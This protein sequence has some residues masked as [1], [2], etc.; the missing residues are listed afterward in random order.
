MMDEIAL[1]EDVRA[2]CEDVSSGTR[3]T[4]SCFW[5]TTSAWRWTLGGSGARGV[6][7][8]IKDVVH[9]TAAAPRGSARPPHHP[10]RRACDL[11]HQ[12][13]RASTK[14]ESPAS[15]VA[16]Q[17]PWRGPPSGSRRRRRRAT[18]ATALRSSTGNPRGSVA[19]REGMTTTIWSGHLKQIYFRARRRTCSRRSFDDDVI[20]VTA[21]GPARR[22]PQGSRPKTKNISTSAF[23]ALRD[24]NASSPRASTVE[25]VNTRRV[26]V[27]VRAHRGAVGPALELLPRALS[28]SILKSSHPFRSRFPRALGSLRCPAGRR[29]GVFSHPCLHALFTFFAA[30]CAASSARV[31]RIASSSSPFGLIGIPIVWPAAALGTEHVVHRGLRLA[32]RAVAHHEPARARR[33]EAVRAPRFPFIGGSPA[34]TRDTICLDR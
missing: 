5:R 33:R 12:R 22:E 13:L 32:Q 6:S 25:D 14:A 7:S 28:R 11:R 30:F 3:P 24:Q 1:A 16:P 17:R 20:A 4:A 18:R 21:C 23:L 8:P 9:R 2:R 15:A 10:E 27:F 19:R 31:A 34:R 29:V 26:H